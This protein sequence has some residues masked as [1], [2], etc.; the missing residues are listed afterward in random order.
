MKKQFI[1]MWEATSIGVYGSE[2]S[3]WIFT[4]ENKYRDKA[5]IVEDNVLLYSE[6]VKGVQFYYTE[7]GMNKAARVGYNK[8]KNHNKTIDYLNRAKKSLA[9]ANEEYERCLELDLKKF[10]L[11]ELLLE[12]ERATDVY[13]YV[14]TYFNS[15]QPQ[16]FSLIERELQEYLSKK[17]PEDKQNDVYSVLTSSDKLDP[18]R[19]EELEWLKIVRKAQQIFGKKK[20]LKLS[21]LKIKKSFYKIFQNHVDKYIHVGR[22]EAF[23]DWDEKHYLDSLN[24]Q[25]NENVNQKRKEIQKNRK[26]LIE[27]KNEY[28]NKYKIDKDVVILTNDIA[29]IGRTRLYLRFGW[30]KASYIFVRA[31]EEILRRKI[32]PFLTFENIWDYSRDEFRRAIK[33][34][35]ELDKKELEGRKKAFLFEVNNGQMTF[36]SGDKAINRK[37]MLAPEK[38]LDIEEFKG[39]IACK[40]K[41]KGEVTVFY[42][43]ELDI[44][45]KMRE[46]KEGNILV[47]GQTR[48]FLMPA[49]RKAGAIIT[50]EGGITSH[51]AIVSRELGIPCIIGTKDA[52][53]ILKDGDIIEVDADRGIVR[54]IK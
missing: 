39:N 1:R 45:K 17:V 26:E 46:M 25:I 7:E 43:S 9:K 5:G 21:D 14:Y 30:T 37:N 34:N 16:S 41:A 49:I 32:R 3:T 36:Y 42:W 27:N 24:K 47:A 51:A 22:I 28:I 10:T 6:G 52:T 13:N 33:E 2:V 50:D 29:E 35:K 8:F 4:P 11:D 31:K 38:K 44:V 23:I 53:K 15:C 20:G 54:K 12:V 18:I 48:P 40:G 19:K